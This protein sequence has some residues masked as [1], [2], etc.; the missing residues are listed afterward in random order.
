MGPDF[1]AGSAHGPASPPAS[2]PRGN[3]PGANGARANGLR[4][5]DPAPGDPNLTDLVGV[6]HRRRWWVIA[7]VALAALV[8]YV[9]GARSPLES[10][11][12]TRLQLVEPSEDGAVSPAS[13]PL[14]LEERQSAVIARA[15][16][17]R[18]RTAVTDALGLEPG[19][20]KSVSAD[21]EEGQSFVTI[22]VTT[23]EGVDTA[24]ITDQVAEWVVEEQRDAMRARSDALAGE[25]RREANAIDT[26]IAAVDGQLEQLSRD[27]AVLTLDANRNAGLDASVD[28]QVAI[29]VKTDKANGLRSTRAALLSTQSD[30]ERQAKEA[31]VAGAV[32]S[33]G[34]ELYQPAGAADTSR[35]FPPIQFGVLAASLALVVLVCAAYFAAYRVDAAHGTPTLPAEPGG[36]GRAPRREESQDDPERGDGADAAN[37]TERS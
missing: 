18:A 13:D 10:R 31:D 11:A 21:A 1:D 32:S 24:A 33:G 8:G 9:L 34:V 15:E 17:P 4:H 12:D 2:G 35:T 36:N 5:N 29:A 27:I 26:E 14:P 37:E 28:P 30:F 22:A 19:A 16:S 3:D 25:L 6:L 23:V 7:I 20:I